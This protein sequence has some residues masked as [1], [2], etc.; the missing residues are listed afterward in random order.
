MRTLVGPAR[1]AEDVRERQVAVEGRFD[2]RLHLGAVPA[3][4]EGPE[5][6]ARPVDPS[7]ALLAKQDDGRGGG[8]PGHHDAEDEER[9]LDARCWR[10]GDGP[11]T[12]AERAEAEAEGAL[13]T[14]EES[15]GPLF[16]LRWRDDLGNNT[17]GQIIA[18]HQTLAEVNA[19]LDANEDVGTFEILDERDMAPACGHL[20]GICGGA[21][22]CECGRPECP[23]TETKDGAS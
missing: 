8:L 20:F 2:A 1:A 9:L 18:E 14:D 17:P 22:A 23:D 12:P 3:T 11:Q 15:P 6:A 21:C 10:C 13:G 4:G 7:A 16:T 19:W 5:G